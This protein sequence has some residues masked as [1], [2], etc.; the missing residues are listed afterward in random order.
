MG[1]ASLAQPGV[2][3]R[4]WEADFVNVWQ[5]WLAVSLFFMLSWPVASCSLIFNERLSARKQISAFP[6]SADYVDL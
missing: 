2:F 5:N 4:C 1:T 6:N 3:S